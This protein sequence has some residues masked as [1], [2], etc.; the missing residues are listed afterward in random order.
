MATHNAI[1]A[2][3]DLANH[4]VVG[5]NEVGVHRK[6]SPE[7]VGYVVDMAQRLDDLIETSKRVMAERKAM[8]LPTW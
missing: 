3:N 4:Y 2:A 1:L 7:Y 5:A 6:M 8:G